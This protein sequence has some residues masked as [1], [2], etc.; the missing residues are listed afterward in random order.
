MR[1][2]RW[3]FGRSAPPAPESFHSVLESLLAEPSRQMISVDA[4]ERSLQQNES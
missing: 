1:F 4:L 2:L 3:L